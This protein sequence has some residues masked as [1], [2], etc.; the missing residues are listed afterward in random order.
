[1]NADHLEMWDP[2]VN[3]HRRV[4]FTADKRMSKGM[5]QNNRRNLEKIKATETISHQTVCRKRG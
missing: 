3:K 2:R 4:A 1:M 5:K